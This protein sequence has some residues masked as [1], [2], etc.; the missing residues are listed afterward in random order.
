LTNK[1]NRWVKKRIPELK[2]ELGG[3]C[4][5]K[6]CGERRLSRLEFAHVRSTPISRSGPRD[7]KQKVADVAAHTASYKLLCERHHDSDKK[8]REHDARM[9]RLGRR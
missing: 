1:A 3:K 4:E 9:R 7:R 6:G 8:A 5:H 2:R